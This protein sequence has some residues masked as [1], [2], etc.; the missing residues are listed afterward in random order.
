ML[1]LLDLTFNRFL[2]LPSGFHC[3]W[4]ES[5]VNLIG[6][7]LLMIKDFSVV[8]FNIF[9]CNFSF[10]IFYYDVSGYKYLCVYS[11]LNILSSL[12][13]EIVFLGKFSIIISLFFLLLSCLYS[14]SGTPITEM[15]VMMSCISQ[16]ICSF[17]FV[18]SID[19]TLNSVIFQF[20]S[21]IEP[22]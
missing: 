12:S 16:W 21:I 3:F 1:I 20:K 13:V 19:L 6:V 2:Y 17:F 22:L 8:A 18:E 14:P 7:L 5:V 15:P 4:L 9:S 11:A 10:F